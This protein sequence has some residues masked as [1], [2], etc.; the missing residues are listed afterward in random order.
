MYTKLALG[1]DWS[2]EGLKLVA[3]GRRFRKL[4]VLDW[5][6]VSEPLAKEGKGKIEEFLKRNQAA[7]ARTIACPPRE[8]FLVRFLDLP[9]EAES[10]LARVIGYQ[11]DTLHPFQGTPISWDSAVVA[12]DAKTKQIRV[13]IA[14]AEQSALD[15]RSQALKELGLR[16]DCLTPAAAPLAGILNALLPEM[17]LVVLGRGSRIEL[18]GFR[19]GSL[20]AAQELASDANP[21]QRLQRELHAFGSVLPPEASKTIPTFTCGPIPEALSGVLAETKSLPLPKLPISAPPRFDVEAMLPAL[22]ASY[23]G[24]RRKPSPALNLLPIESRLRPSRWGRVPVYALGASAM[25]LGLMLLAHG[26]IETALY[27]RALDRQ[28]QRLRS[29]AEAAGQRNEQVARLSERVKLLESLRGETWQK[30]HIM[31]E[32]TTLL[33]D[34]T[35]AQDLQV[36]QGS[37]EFSGYSNR[38]AELIQ[39]LENS[40]Y[41]SQVEFASPITRGADN[42]EAFRIRMR[43]GKPALH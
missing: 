37:V 5:L 8:G 17:A 28:I 25:L 33:P 7:E 6:Q 11:I 1:V 10:Q 34:G 27:G 4:V 32:L 35:W 40:P 12:R 22:A 41:F 42:K 39:P 14:I 23:A 30:L 13:M 21:A 29:Q 24:L 9:G 20:V 2:A 19:Q 16:V 26:L 3:A 38:A 18:F 36:G 43:V 15:R 31:R